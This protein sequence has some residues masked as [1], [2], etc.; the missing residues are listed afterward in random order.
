VVL[1]CITLLPISTRVLSAGPLSTSSVALYSA[2]LLAT[3]IA[4]FVF[5]RLAFSLSVPAGE[6][7]TP[8]R[9]PRTLSSYF[10]IS[11]H[12]CAFIIA[13]FHPWAS[14]SLWIVALTTPGIESWVHRVNARAIQGDAQVL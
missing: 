8:S 14:L 1:L 10:A 3:S 13:F 5:R 9:L 11:V 12:S 7:L 4:E 2:N 6:T